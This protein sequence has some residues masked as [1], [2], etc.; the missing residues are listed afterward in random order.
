MVRG[1]DWAAVSLAVHLLLVLV[2][3]IAG[4]I[5]PSFTGNWLRARGAMPL[6]AIHR[7][8]EQVVIPLTATVGLAD[9]LMPGTPLTG[10]LA[11]TAALVHGMR[12]ARWRGLA[13]S[14]GLEPDP[15]VAPGNGPGE[16]EQADAEEH[17]VCTLKEGQNP[18]R[19]APRA[20]VQPAAENQGLEHK[21]DQ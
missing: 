14:A 21:Q 19:V 6:P 18:I 2:S 4:R 1:G 8:I 12:L 10:G 17:P 5:V 15:S 7:S 20:L 9:A 3:L 16:R 11:I 13:T